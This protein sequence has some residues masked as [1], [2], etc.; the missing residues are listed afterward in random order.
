MLEKMAAFFE[1][2]MD[3]YEAHML[4]NIE[5]A[6]EFYPF[7]AQNLP[8][9]PGA[10]ILD[11]GCGTGLELEYYFVLNPDAK[12]TG[13]DLS[14]QMLQAL[15]EKFPHKQIK[16]I[17]GSYFDLPFELESYDGAVS[18]ESLHH[19]TQAEKSP[20]YNK[21]WHAL[22]PGCAFLLTD[23]FALSDEQ[24]LSF[25]QE[26]LRLRQEAGIC[27]EEF[28]HFDTPLTVEHEV[29]AL[30]HAGFASVQVLK[31]WGATYCIKAT[32]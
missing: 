3:G 18:V 13:V 23:Y 2:R 5:G 17:Q 31:N 32:K 12:V 9:Q 7:T 30:Q 25:R 11:L 14:A 1:A 28:Y 15:K 24:E 29:Q 16:L 27:D 6:E 20:L 26:W 4:Q 8:L 21:L 19:F 10:K 22:K